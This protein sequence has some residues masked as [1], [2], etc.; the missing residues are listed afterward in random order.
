MADNKI[1]NSLPVFS[2]SIPEH[3]D[4]FLGPSFF[5]PYA[6][7]FTNRIDPAGIETVLEIGCGTG[8]VT[9]HLRKILPP[10]CQFIASDISPDM[11][12][13]AK[14]KLKGENIDWRII[15]AVQLPFEDNSIDMLV[16]CFAYMFVEDKEKAFAEA[17]RVL[18]EGGTFF[19][20][21][22]DMLERN[23]PSNEFRKIVKR[24]LGDNIPKN[25]K[26][27]FAFYDHE[28]IAEYLRGAGFSNISIESVMKTSVFPT[29]KEAAYGFSHGGS[30]YHE[31]MNRNPSW[32]A[33]ICRELEQALI[34][35]YGDHP[36][37]APM[38]AV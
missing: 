6:I 18:K 36:M 24:Y 11:L 32:I 23:G 15:D 2:G 25:Y 38:S 29:A 5:E 28:E 14:T 33:E 4:A 9:R 16:S 30:L 17:G 7:D 10:S 27:P 37:A 22:W 21:T 12:E 35:K 3:Y 31:I 26:L 20:T 13:V 1:S 19:F 34:D 8:R